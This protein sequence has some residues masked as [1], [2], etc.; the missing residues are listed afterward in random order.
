MEN[1]SKIK[2]P[3]QNALEKKLN[4]DQLFELRFNQSE[5]SKLAE[6]ITGIRP[7]DPRMLDRLII[8]QKILR[9]KYNLPSLESRKEYSFAEYERIL[10][11][12]AEKN[13][14]IIRDKN[15][16][17]RFFEKYMANAS[18]D[19]DLHS[20]FI[21]MKRNTDNEY[22]KSL[23]T[24]EHELIHAEQEIHGKGMP[25]ELMEYEAYVASMNMPKFKDAPGDIEPVLFSFCIGVSTNIW[26]A[27][28]KEGEKGF[29]EPIWRNP[30]YFLKNIDHIS[31]EEIEIYK[32]KLVSN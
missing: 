27:Q 21:D 17:V 6:Y 23:I 5:A 9:T 12:I 7:E 8:D 4:K 26:Y 20:I 15:E 14:V 13:N 2:R 19:E 3:A 25:I 32:K 18:Y 16:H 28:N 11:E 30:E 24:L 1:L 29:T 31:D 10:Y 22:G